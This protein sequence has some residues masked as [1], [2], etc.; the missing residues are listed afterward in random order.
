[1]FGDILHFYLFRSSKEK[2]FYVIVAHIYIYYTFIDISRLNKMKSTLIW[3]LM[4]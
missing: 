3:N 2:Y 4:F 1:M